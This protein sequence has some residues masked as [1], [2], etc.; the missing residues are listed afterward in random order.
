[1]KIIFYCQKNFFNCIEDYLKP[2]ISF[3]NAQL[4]IFQKFNSLQNANYHI[5]IQNIP[6]NISGEN[7]ILFN[8]EQLTRKDFKLECQKNTIVLDYAIGNLKFIKN[9]KYCIP[10]LYNPDEIYN[11]EKIYDVCF[12]GGLSKKRKKILNKLDKIGIKVNR[13]KAWGKK[14]DKELFKHK[15]LLNIGFDDDYQIFESIRC[16]RCVYNKM[17]VI[18]DHKIDMKKTS[19]K[20]H[21]FFIPEN[22]FVNPVKFVLHNY[23]EVY[24]KLKLDNIKIKHPNIPK[25][26]LEQN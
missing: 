21:I 17:I 1:M 14:R 20:K 15:I 9:E 18:S 5:F 11:F 26:L 6:N 8:F 23:E 24:N 16:D 13:I 25:F 7:I 22:Y 12:I 3:L 10:Y 19:L 4:I 2:L